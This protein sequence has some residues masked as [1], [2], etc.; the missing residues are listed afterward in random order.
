MLRRTPPTYVTLTNMGT[1]A[2]LDELAANECCCCARESCN[3]LSCAAADEVVRTAALQYSTTTSG[4]QTHVT[5]YKSNR[6]KPKGV[7]RV[8]RTSLVS[9]IELVHLK[10]VFSLDLACR[11]SSMLHKRASS[12]RA[13]TTCE[14]M[15]C[16]A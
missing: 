14:S 1:R 5:R 11:R 8:L 13:S 10:L 16:C 6:R 4:Q 3:Q 2:A 15:C 9:S 7:C 12:A